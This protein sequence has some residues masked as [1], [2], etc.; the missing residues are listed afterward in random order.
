MKVYVVIDSGAYVG[1]HETS[2]L[3]IFS[4]KEKAKEKFK[5]AVEWLKIDIGTYAEDTNEVV[6]DEDWIITEREDMFYVYDVSY[7][8]HNFETIWIEEKEV[9]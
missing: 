3:G 5:N 6:I 2:I 1:V 8:S 7:G 4:N 9:E